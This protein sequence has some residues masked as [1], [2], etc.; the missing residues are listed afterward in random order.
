MLPPKLPIT[1]TAC[2]TTTITANS[3]ADHSNTNANSDP[4]V[5]FSSTSFSSLDYSLSLSFS[6]CSP[7]AL[8]DTLVGAR[9]KEEAARILKEA[10]R[11]LQN[12]NDDGADN[13]GTAIHETAQ[14]AGMAP[15]FRTRPALSAIN[16]GT[17][18]NANE[19][20]ANLVN[21]PR[22]LY[23]LWN[24]YEVGVKGNKAARCFTAAERGKVKHKYCRRRKF[25][26]AMERLIATGSDSPTAI[27][28]IYTVY[29]VKQKVS[30]ILRALG[31]DEA[32]GGHAL[33]RGPL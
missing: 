17:A 11:L 19:G 9:G 2:T 15:V 20:P 28:R 12:E 18:A 21:C 29:G 7:Q 22:D 10:S 1:R 13:G 30:Y 5:T 6:S 31:P 26:G 14:R 4:V 32:N 16:E 3:T 33:L 24:E 8:A 25:W 23:T 27:R